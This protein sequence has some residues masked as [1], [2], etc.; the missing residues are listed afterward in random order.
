VLVGVEPSYMSF[1]EEP[2]AGV[3]EPNWPSQTYDNGL[4]AY[5]RPQ[6]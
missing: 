5:F 1:L 4:Q 3:I 2:L 6:R